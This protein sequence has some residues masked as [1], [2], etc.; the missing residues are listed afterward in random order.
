MDK[1][2]PI[3]TGTATRG[4][5]DVVM[6]AAFTSPYRLGTPDGAV[7]EEVG[8]DQ[9]T[10]A[11]PTQLRRFAD[12]RSSIS[13]A[14]GTVETVLEEVAGAHPALARQILDDDGKL[15]RFVNL[16]LWTSDIRN[17]QRE[18]TKVEAGDVL[19]ILWAMSGG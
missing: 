13:C 18:R 7:L 4:E 12:G 19:T 3:E 2:E 6:A 5:Q 11:L 8:I 10:V 17:L 16:Y 15:R 14:P 1:S 9:V